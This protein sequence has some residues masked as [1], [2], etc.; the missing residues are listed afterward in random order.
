L[1]ATVEV[2][3]S[4]RQYP[5]F[6]YLWLK[7]VTGFDP[8]QHCLPCLL[9]AQSGRVRLDMPARR[10][11]LLDEA[12][13]RY[14]YLCGGLEVYEKNLH[15]AMELAEG[16]VFAVRAANGA[17]FMFRGLRRLEI[18]PLQKGFCGLSPKFTTCR[19]FQFGMAMFGDRRRRINGSSI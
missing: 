8:S 10:P 4:P 17:T 16:E 14:L 3:R 18:P 13:G 2:S 9:G 6:W 19:N 12:K 15:V 7:Y 1:T 5:A 11:I